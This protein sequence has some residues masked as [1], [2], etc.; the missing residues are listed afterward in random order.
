MSEN[1]YQMKFKNIIPIC[2]LFNGTL[3]L[4]QPSP[5]EEKIEVMP[6]IQSL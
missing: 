4:P 1:K 2:F 6:I 3:C 5:A